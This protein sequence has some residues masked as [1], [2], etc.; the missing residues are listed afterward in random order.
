MFTY[1]YQKTVLNPQRLMDEVEQ[2]SL[3]RPD[4][5]ETSGSSVTLHFSNALGSGQELTLE[6]IVTEHEAQSADEY[7]RD[8]V[9]EAKNF[10]LRVENDFI[11][12]NVKLGITQLGLTNHVRKTLREVRDA[13]GSG[14]LKDAVTEIKNLNSADFDATILTPARLLAFRNKLEQWLQVPLAT[15]WNDPETWL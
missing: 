1:I 9:L 10:G 5:V 14:S 15:A 8:V 6:G 2:S 3:P 4:Y 11:V 7:I 13:V 12:E